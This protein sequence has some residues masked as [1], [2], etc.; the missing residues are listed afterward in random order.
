MADSHGDANAI[1]M[2]VDFLKG[3]ACHALYHL[4]DICDARR[5]E[6]ADDCVELVIH[7]GIRAVM[8]NNDHTLTADA[9][10]RK[11]AGIRR[12]TLS[13]L[14]NLPLRLSVG[15]ARL[16]HS[17]PFI[18]RLGLSAMI[19]GIGQREA[20][21]FF[22]ENPDGLL[23]RGHS[24]QPELISPGEADI[25]FSSLVAGQTIELAAV[26]PC[27]VTCGALTAGWA[28]IWEPDGD[29]LQCCRFS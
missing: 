3:N 5:W 19:G 7:C 24:H 18:K 10:G 27:I 14:E 29:R 13:F 9:R 23:F 11:P 21:T 6:T 17:R 15:S 16:V 26:R 22:R 28:M 20:G 2:A 12:D 4:G 8:G 25:R 1:V